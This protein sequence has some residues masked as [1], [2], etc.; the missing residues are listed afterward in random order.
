MH[1][2]ACKER[3]CTGK[4]S[5]GRETGVRYRGDGKYLGGRGGKL[6]N[7]GCVA[8]KTIDGLEHASQE[9]RES[10]QNSRNARGYSNPNSQFKQVRSCNKSQ[11]DSEADPRFA[12]RIERRT[13]IE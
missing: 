13:L 1:F 12:K 11:G 5:N 10:D 4:K 9:L 3:G 6:G 2:L 7:Q 8:C